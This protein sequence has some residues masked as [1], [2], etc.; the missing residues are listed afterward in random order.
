MLALLMNA[1]Q[2]PLF[3]QLTDESDIRLC[4]QEAYTRLEMGEM[5]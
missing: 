3:L 5:I 4:L 1:P 2:I